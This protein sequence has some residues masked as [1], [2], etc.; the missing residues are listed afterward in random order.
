MNEMAIIIRK[1]RL[2]PRINGIPVDFA[3]V[4]EYFNRA[5]EKM[6]FHGFREKRL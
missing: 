5:L 2:K 4:K 3:Q 6:L 1:P